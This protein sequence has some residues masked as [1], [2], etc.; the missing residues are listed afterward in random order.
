[1][2]LEAH[3]AKNLRVRRRALIVIGQARPVGSGDRLSR[4]HSGARDKEQLQQSPA[5]DQPPP[6][7]GQLHRLGRLRPRIG[8]RDVDH[9]VVKL[10]LQ[11]LYNRLWVGS[12]RSSPLATWWMRLPMIA[13]GV[14]A[15]N[16]LRLPNGDPYGVVQ[17]VVT[18]N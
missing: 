16:S 1:M 11:L 4:A 8:A 13:Q 2:P 10:T 15:F 3:F 12:H 7:Q 6:E 5:Q 14:M 18:L 17:I 9:Q